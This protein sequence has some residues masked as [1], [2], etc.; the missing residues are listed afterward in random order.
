MNLKKIN[1]FV[2]KNTN[3]VSLLHFKLVLNEFV[4]T[5]DI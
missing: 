5:E 4:H 3:L 2:S 1:R